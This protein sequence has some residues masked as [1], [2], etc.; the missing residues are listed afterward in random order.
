MKIYFSKTMLN[1]PIYLSKFKP[2]NLFIFIFSGICL[3]T[4]NPKGMTQEYFG[5]VPL[6]PPM[7]PNT[8]NT[9][10]PQTEFGQS[11]PLPIPIEYEYQSPQV[12]PVYSNT[13]ATGTIY[14]VEVDS[15]NQLLLQSVRTIE[16]TAF[17]RRGE[18]VIQVGLF[19]DALNAQNMVQRLSAQGITA[20]VVQISNPNVASSVGSSSL[21]VYGTIETQGYFVII[22]GQMDN[23]FNIAGRIKQSGVPDNALRLRSAPLGPHV[24]VGPFGKREEAER[25]SIYLRSTGLDARVYFGH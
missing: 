8:P 12:S 18:G 24:A 10:T 11:N 3:L 6:P 15:E 19:R 1:L 9:N 14:R 7:P 17:I 5:N 20:R 22:P 21:N 16:P 2:K 13:V 23:L 4:L 25:W